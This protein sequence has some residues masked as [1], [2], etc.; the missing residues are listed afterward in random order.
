MTIYKSL[1]NKLRGE[2][3]R[4]IFRRHML[5]TDGSIFKLLP[6]CVVYPADRGDV[7]EIL[8]FAREHNLSVHARGTGSGVCG[9]ALG[10]GIVVDFTKH[11]N[12]LI[13]LDLDGHSFECEPGFR[14]G[15]LD[16]ALKGSNLFFPPDPSSGEYASFGGMYNTNASGAHSVKYG[17]VGDYCLDADMVLSNGSVITLSDLISR[18][19]H[20][21]PEQLK[22][23]FDLY[24]NNAAII[25][26][27]Y[28]PVRFNTT[29]YNL[30]NLVT[31]G[32]LDLRRLF[33]G[34]EGTLGIITRLK[35]KLLEKPAHDSLVVAYFKDIVS[36][37]KAVEKILPLTPCGIEV[38]D[39]S[40]LD[41][42]RKNDPS[43]DAAMP[44]EI[45]NLLLIGFDEHTRKACLEKAEAAGSLIRENNWSDTFHLAVSREEQANFWAIRKAAVPI[46]YRLKGEKKVLALIEDAAVPVDR[47]VE[48]FKG[49][50]KLLG[51][52]GVNF[53]LFGH[54]SKGL[55]HTRPMLNLKDKHDVN[56]L[57]PIAD[58]VFKL[59]NALGGAISGEHGDGRLRSPYIR[60]QY[61]DIFH[62]FQETK[63]ILDPDNLLNPDIITNE[64][65]NGL[66]QSLRYGPEYN[67]EPIYQ[68]PIFQSSD[69]LNEVEKCH[70]CSKCT[71][72]T[73]AT[74]MCPVYKST[75]DE[76]AAPKAKANILRA[77][78]SGAIEEKQAYADGLFHVL[79][80]CINC[81][82]CHHECPSQVNI[83]RMVMAAKA[84]YA[85]K[86]GPGLT[87]RL[88]TS[89][90]TGARLTHGLSHLVM[91]IMD[92]PLI[93]QAGEKLLGISA[94]RPLIGF[95]KE[96]LEKRLRN[97][98]LLP[99]G[100]Q[101]QSKKVLYFPGCYASWIRPETAMAFIKILSAL[102]MKVYVPPT[103]C[104]GLPMLSKGMTAQAC[105]TIE[106]NL[107]QW[108]E[109][110][111]EVDHIAVTC[112]TC[113]LALKSKWQYL[114]HTRLVREVAA[115]TIHGTRLIQDHMDGLDLKETRR[116]IAYHTPCHLKVQ[117]EATSS[118]EMLKAIPGIEV[119][120]LES[121]CCGMAGT[122]GM[123]AKNFD[124][125]QKI[126]SDLI[127]QLNC[128]GASAGATDCPTCTMQMQAFWDKPVIHPVEIVTQCL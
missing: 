61:P 18:D 53:V 81:G 48:Y 7:V 91:P 8:S 5:A 93:K 28:P 105:G 126:G 59:V 54:I 4:D 118:I 128:S 49:I 104:C 63:K 41:L 90:D 74:R 84:D 12:R 17:N 46:L 36:S 72:V 52:L 119:N 99:A 82:S 13:R 121:H 106:K 2:L 98:A 68:S 58:G 110:V 123:M 25:E 38:M 78:V 69:F 71:T 103:H 21:L 10:Q 89:A 43:L 6:A 60:A 64:A 101:A 127:Q 11:M 44:E 51:D 45:D 19:E 102:G 35:F 24:Q 108:G 34:A 109:L 62:L 32:H 15:E 26:K 92:H 73:H 33:A 16:Q 122:W 9:S 50:Y 87:D 3:H 77:L 117:P 20:K 124:L 115:K 66:T 116:K 57:K 30:R 56:L 88:L 47:L 27:A 42:A 79:N 86:F 111:K 29:G 97:P 22:P 23:L 65:P 76:A 113:G 120:P 1:A 114:N 75:R 31:D 55:M 94:Q 37:A 95:A 80:H 70:G 14:L 83:P 39:K 67:A 125:S 107:K 96:S 112:S 85:K 40:L 100:S